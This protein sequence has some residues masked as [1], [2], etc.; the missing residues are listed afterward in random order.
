MATQAE[1]SINS[2]YQATV[3]FPLDSINLSFFFF[4]LT[5]TPTLQLLFSLVLRPYGIFQSF[6]LINVREGETFVLY[7]QMRSFFLATNNVCSSDKVKKSIWY[8]YT[9]IYI[10]FSRKP[11]VCIFFSSIWRKES[12]CRIDF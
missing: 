3:S 9:R 8:I 2:V 4:F 12:H 7:R 10:F 6:R 5:E 1:P 11:E